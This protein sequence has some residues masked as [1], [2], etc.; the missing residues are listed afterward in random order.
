MR[1]SP[2]ESASTENNSWPFIEAR[3]VLRHYDKNMRTPDAPIILETGY[4]PSGL[5]HIGTFAEIVRTSMVRHALVQLVPNIKTRLICFSDDMDGLRKIPDNVPNHDMLTAHLDKPLSAVPDPFGT[6]ASFAAHNNARLCSFLDDF[7]FVYEFAS[8]TDYYTS[9]RM[10]AALRLVLAHYDAVCDIIVPTLSKERAAQYSPFLPICPDSG[11]ILYV[12]AEGIDADA[13]TMCYRHPHT[14]RVVE[15][16]VTGGATKLQW[17]V[18]WAMRWVALGVDYEMYGKDLTESAVLS[19]RICRLLGAVP[20]AGFAYEMFLDVAGEKISKSRGNGLEVDEWRR[21]APPE[22]L[23]FYMYQNPKRAKR[24]YFDVIPKT[25][26]DYLAALK[27]YASDVRNNPDILHDN[28]IWHVYGALG[29]SIPSPLPISFALLLNLVSA[30]NAATPEILWGFIS[31]YNKTLK[32]GKHHLLD[33]LVAYALVFYRDFVAPHKNYRPPNS[34]ERKALGVLI[35]HFEKLPPHA[36]EKAIQN[37]TYTVGKEFFADHLGDWFSA[38]YEILLGQKQ[39]PRFG[40][41]A[42]LYGLHKTMD[43]LRARLDNDVNA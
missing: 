30:S 38:L 22:S 39:G 42:A 26:D 7:G 19:G 8:A 15:T 3:A 24:L 23:A 27:K 4:G 21:Y 20:P 10:D 6:Y 29:N 37:E 17:K 34:V 16:L 35:A 11:R 43:L 12:A 25:V 33:A 2:T 28:P 32:A 40:T 41:F 1:V 5:P 9:G 13:G 36:D 31:K 18:D 14:G